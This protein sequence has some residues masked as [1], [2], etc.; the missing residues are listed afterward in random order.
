MPLWHCRKY[1]VGSKGRR[2]AKSSSCRTGSSISLPDDT[3]SRR[4]VLLALAVGA[5]AALSGCGW[6]P[7]YADLEAGPA[8]EELR[9]IHVDPILER[10]GQRLEIALRNSLNPTG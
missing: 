9:A 4:R 7:L 5:P 8:S 3:R 2:R 10:I 6:R 1:C